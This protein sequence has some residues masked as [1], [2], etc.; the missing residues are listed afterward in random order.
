ME[1]GECGTVGQC[2]GRTPV[3]I[4]YG[5]MVQEAKKMYVPVDVDQS[6]R[7]DADQSERKNADQSEGRTLANGVAALA[8][9]LL[10]GSLRVTT[11]DLR[12]Q[13]KATS[14]NCLR[15]AVEPSK[16]RNYWNF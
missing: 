6:D 8:F 4:I 3:G 15:N 10:A 2:D 12:R 13:T 14:H 5:R 11:S 7:V 9:F 16:S 1:G